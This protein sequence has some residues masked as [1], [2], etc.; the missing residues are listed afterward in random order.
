MNGD[1]AFV[2]EYPADI[3]DIVGLHYN[4]PVI[5]DDI[6]VY[7][8]L[9]IR[10]DDPNLYLHIRAIPNDNIA[11]M[12]VTGIHI[13]AL[14]G[15]IDKPILNASNLCIL[16]DSS[17][18]YGCKVTLPECNIQDI[19]NKTSPFVNYNGRFSFSAHVGYQY[20]KK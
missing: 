5:Q 9:E 7:F 4:D 6:V 16:N 18:R 11:V 15:S 8:I 2:V 3:V 14:I 20:I 19:K 12:T 1:T 10:K 17:K 13:H